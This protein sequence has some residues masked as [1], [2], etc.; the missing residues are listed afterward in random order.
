LKTITSED[1][2]NANDIVDPN[3]ENPSPSEPLVDP[4]SD[5]ENSANNVILTS[6]TSTLVTKH[7]HKNAG[8]KIS[9]DKKLSL[10]TTK[11]TFITKFN[12]NNVNKNENLDQKPSLSS[13]NSSMLL[14]TE[15][16]SK[17]K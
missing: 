6:T 1:L 10:S 15:S 16:V 2:I 13:T 12:D 4:T 8:R 14:S 7:R 11:P 17:K 5:E 9:F 3:D